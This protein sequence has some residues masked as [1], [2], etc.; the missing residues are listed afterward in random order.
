MHPEALGTGVEARNTGSRDNF[1]TGGNA[2]GGQG[3]LGAG[4][5]GES[6]KTKWSGTPRR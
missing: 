3:I 1:V 2:P 6:V 4:S 5:G